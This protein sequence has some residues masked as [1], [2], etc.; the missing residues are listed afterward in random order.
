MNSYLEILFWTITVYII[1]VAIVHFIKVVRE[2][3]ENNV[4]LTKAIIYLAGGLTLAMLL[5]YKPFGASI[6]KIADKLGKRPIS[7]ATETVLIT[8]TTMGPTSV[9]V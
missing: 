2:K 4:N 9:S 1:A 7:T 3:K 5:L 8:S 6:V